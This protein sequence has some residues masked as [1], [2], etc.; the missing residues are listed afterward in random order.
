MMLVDARYVLSLR[1][2]VSYNEEACIYIAL[3]LWQ[4]VVEERVRVYCYPELDSCLLA[5]ELIGQVDT[6]TELELKMLFLNSLSLLPVVLLLFLVSLTIVMVTAAWFTRRLEALCEMT[7]LS[8]GI[9]SLLSAIG[10]N[11]PN[12]AASAV[13][14]IGGHTDVGI[15][16]IVGSSVYNIAIILGLC[17]L[18]SPEASGITLNAQESQ[19]VRGI[20]WYGLT[21]MLSILGVLALLAATPTAGEVRKAGPALFLLPS[22]SAVVLG[23]FSALIV[24][25]LR[26]SHPAP[27]SSLATH[28]HAHLSTSPSV[29]VFSLSGEVAL[30]LMLTLMGVVV[31]VQSGQAM[32]VDLHLP[33]ALTGLV[34][35]A[36]ATSLPNTVVAVS[37]TRTDEA[38]A[39]VE[40]IF[41]SNSINTALGVALPLLFWQGTLHDRSFLFLDMPLTI[42]LTLG[43][44]VG[45]F[46]RRMSR[47]FGLV[48]LCIYAAWV[49]VHLWI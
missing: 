18:A 27:T 36:V 8:I 38:A 1:F 35:L 19:D 46:R 25:I 45:V 10:A 6:T 47:G 48:L 28:S 15:G 42:V 31:M 22:A 39:C 23:I 21:I 13:A 20:A 12:Y 11:I 29:R 16:I 43:M 40:E 32:S 2:P 4:P 14:I 26:R 3:S 7:G 34:V 24:H 9:L 37:L 49:I 17:T 5:E 41:S 33:Q 44:I 30:S